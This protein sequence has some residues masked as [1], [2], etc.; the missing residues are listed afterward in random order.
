M[1]KETKILLETGTNE[2]EILEF[3]VDT[4]SDKDARHCFG[5]NVAKVLE[6]IE[7]PGLHTLESA[8]HPCHL[9]VI[10]LRGEPLPVLDLAAWLQLAR[11]TDEHEVILVTEINKLFTGFLV[12]GV[13]QIHR[14]SWDEV[15]P[16]SP[17]M[18]D[19]D[20]NCITAL[21]KLEDHFVQLLDLEQL[22]A[23]LDPSTRP[24]AIETAFP[25][26]P[27]P[28][29]LI[30]D[31]SASI[32]NVLVQNLTGADFEVQTASNGEQALQ[33]LLAIKETATA[34]GRPITDWVDVVVSDVEMPRMD[35]Y[36]LTRKIKEDP[37]LKAL[38]VILFSSLISDNIRHKGVTVGAD[39]QISKP[40]FG[41][42]SGRCLS[43]IQAHRQA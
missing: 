21:V 11:V 25:D 5:I 32:R 12:T 26:G 27:R 38:P 4:G 14:V 20:S 30:A 19:M 29:A 36:T 23:E 28:K 1:Q 10:S 37:V 9:G 39:D 7:S 18:A 24:K 6:V 35:G 2:M 43:L 22:L 16:P 33:K 17:Y 34:E 3:Y 41:E 15:E 8:P 31:D 42:L 13:T 40:E